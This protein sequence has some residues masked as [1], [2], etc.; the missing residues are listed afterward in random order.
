MSAK[1]TVEF[2]LL[3]YLS[4]ENGKYILK[5]IRIC[6]TIDMHIACFKKKNLVCNL[7]HKKE[8]EIKK[9]SATSR[10]DITSFLCFPEHE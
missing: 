10:I 3:A 1:R 8:R 6:L 9:Q 4:F 7:I 2:P 5:N